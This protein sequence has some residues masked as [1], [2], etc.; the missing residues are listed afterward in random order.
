[1]QG[2]HTGGRGIDIEHSRALFLT[3]KRKPGHRDY[4]LD[5]DKIGFVNAIRNNGG[6]GETEY[7]E[8]DDKCLEILWEALK[9]KREA[10]SAAADKSADKT[11]TDI[12]FQRQKRQIFELAISDGVLSLDSPFAKVMFNRW[13][14]REKTCG[15]EDA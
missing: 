5:D 1:M 13:G 2:F 6:N 12:L 7:A 3:G 4:V 8:I 10:N 9:K 14:H 15:K 11:F